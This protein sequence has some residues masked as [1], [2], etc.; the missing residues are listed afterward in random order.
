ML[1]I[2]TI[3]FQVSPFLPFFKKKNYFDV[4][5]HFS[6][7]PFCFSP[8]HEFLGSCSLHLFGITTWLGVGG[9]GY[10]GN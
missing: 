7:V 2:R 3:N 9:D 8:F 6:F 1:A 10:F 4:F 5:F